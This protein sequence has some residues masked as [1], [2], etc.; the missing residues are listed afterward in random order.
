MRSL[1]CILLLA[2]AAHAAEQAVL[3]PASSLPAS[4]SMS[5]SLQS[6]LQSGSA[7]AVGISDLSGSLA[8]LSGISAA[9]PSMS[10]MAPAASMSL[11]QAIGSSV[12][13]AG[14]VSS[15][16]FGSQS[17]ASLPDMH[18]LWDGKPLRCKGVKKGVCCTKVKFCCKEGYRC[19]PNGKAHCVRAPTI[20]VKPVIVVNTPNNGI[21]ADQLAQAQAQ[22]AQQQQSGAQLDEQVDEEPK[23][24]K[25]KDGVVVVLKNSNTIHKGDCK[26]KKG[27]KGKSQ[28]STTSTF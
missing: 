2:V 13:F 27:C 6:A 10:S 9:S 1:L 15:A 3:Q 28:T 17:D 14:S 22:F 19:D 20:I 18:C 8:S 26:G 5:R 24:K 16:S 11:S 25:D 23:A 7:G 21:T 12:G 4:I